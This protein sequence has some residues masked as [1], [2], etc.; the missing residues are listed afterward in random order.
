MQKLFLLAALL[1]TVAVVPTFS[2]TP[3]KTG[4]PNNSV[5]QTVLKL[6]QDWL[7]ADEKQDRAALDRIIADDFLGTGPRGSTV[8]KTDVIPREGSGGGGLSIT[9]EDVKARVFGDTAIV[10]GRGIRKSQ[11]QGE[12]RFTVVFAKRE[13]RWQMVAGHL[14]AVPRQ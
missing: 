11:E 13:N 3:V 2:Q 7:V 4:E 12:L 10:T 1:L 6:T 8:T 14:S 5:E 9:A